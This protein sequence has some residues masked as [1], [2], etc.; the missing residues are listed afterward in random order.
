MPH[1]ELKFDFHKGL[2][3]GHL[4]AFAE[5]RREALEIAAKVAGQ[6]GLHF[7]ITS[8]A[9]LIDATFGSAEV[10]AQ[11]L[12]K[13]DGMALVARSLSQLD[14]DQ[15]IYYSAH[16]GSHTNDPHIQEARIAAAL[17]T[18]CISMHCERFDF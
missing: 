18:A 4:E 5:T 13:K 6:F 12:Q 9:E 7:G 8:R 3:F 15:A 14:Q 17:A 2:D 1:F 10:L 16:D 11:A